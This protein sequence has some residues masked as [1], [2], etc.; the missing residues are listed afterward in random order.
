MNDGKSV[1]YNVKRRSKNNLPVLII[2]GAGFIGSNLAEHFLKSGTPVKIFDNLSRTG[3]ERNLT[4]LKNSYGNLVETIVGDVRNTESIAKAILGVSAVFNFAAQVAVTTSLKNPVHDFETNLHGTLNILEAVRRG[5]PDAPVIFTST[6]KVYGGLDDI[7]LRS[8]KTRY[9]P[10]DDRIKSCGISEQ[11]TL[12][13]HSPY[14]CSK[15]GAEQYVL[16][17]SRCFNLRTA[18]F[19]MSCIYGPHQ[20][21]NE[22]QG[23]VAHFLIQ[24]LNK[25]AIILYGDG[26]QV[27]DI[28]FISDLVNAFKLSLKNIDKIS[29]QPFNIGGGISNTI[30]LIELLKIIEQLTSEKINV[31]FDRWRTGDQKYYVSDTAKFT[32]AVGWKQQIDVKTGVKKL[33]RW[34]VKNHPSD[35]RVPA[36]KIFLINDSNRTRELAV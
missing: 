14:G 29:G 26:K 18:V 22:D 25:K 15:G 6:N 9:E 34:L 16:D 31:S 19:R 27:R 8:K 11:R 1:G 4:W 28:L 2:G 3:I 5:N 24:A 7:K 12:D 30:S 23:W 13:F 36:Q 21:G 33:Y 32:S 35:E 10:E 17:Y 20:Y